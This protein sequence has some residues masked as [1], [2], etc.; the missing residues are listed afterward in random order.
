MNC[1]ETRDLLHCLI[2]N[3]LDDAESQ[4]V[5]AH[6]SNCK[7]CRS[8]LSEHIRLSGILQSNMPWIGKLYFA[9][10]HASYH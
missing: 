3:E 1:E 10:Y 9:R 4:A 6:L 5:L 2:Q 8:A 7:P